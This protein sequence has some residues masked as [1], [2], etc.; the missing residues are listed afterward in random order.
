MILAALLAGALSF[1]L[2]QTMVIFALPDIARDLDVSA[3]AAAWVLTSTLVSASVTTPLIGRLGDLHGKRRVLTGV[4]VVFS[5]GSVLCAVSR[6]FGPLLAGR[7]LCG[8]GAGTFALGPGILRDTLAADRLAVGVGMLSAVFGLGTALGLALSGVVVDQLDVSVIYWLGLALALPAALATVCV[9]PPSPTVPGARIDWIGAALLSLALM[10][11][12]V[13][14]SRAN[15]WGWLGAPTLGLTLAGAGLGAALLAHERRHAQPLLDVRVLRRRAVAA[16]DLAAWLVG[17]ATFSAYLLVP[18]LAQTPVSTGYGL[19]LSAT[20]AGLLLFP[21]SFGLLAMGPLSGVLGARIGFRT[22]L[23]AGAIVT[24]AACGWMSVAHSEP[25]QLV[26]GGFVLGIGLGAAFA[27]MINIIVLAVPRTQVS[28]A[29]GINTVMRTIGGA[30][31]ATLTTA[32][33][34]S[35]LAAGAWPAERGYTGGFALAALG[36]ALA[37]A[38]ALTIPVSS[39]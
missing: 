15:A 6:S 10:C 27:S 22:V 38:L 20:S 30:F 16:T 26:A 31:G 13:A 18:Q 37:C 1:A 28:V 5:L 3:S 21:S 12:L 9:V 23:A 19:G 8:V 4:L 25:W 33:L 2:S 36:A 24:A 39:R 17:L 11:V 7:V 35:G 34:T 32:I 14:L 29:S